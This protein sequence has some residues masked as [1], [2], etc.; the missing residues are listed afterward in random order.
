MTALAVKL[1][2]NLGSSHAELLG[3][4]GYSAERVTEEGLSGAEDRK[5]WDRVVAEG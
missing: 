4:A 2:E 3:K 1:D 5:V